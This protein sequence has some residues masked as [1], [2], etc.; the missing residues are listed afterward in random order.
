MHQRDGARSTAF[1]LDVYSQRPLAFLE[2]ASAEPTGH[3][4][5]LVVQAGDETRPEWLASAEIVCDERQP[6]DSVLFRI[7]EEPSV[8]FFISG[9][10]FGAFVLSTDGAHLRCMPAGRPDDAWQRLLIAQVLPFA[11]LLHD[12]EVFHASAVVSDGRAVAFIG[13]SRAGKTSVA[14]E[15]CL[16]GATFLADD[17]LAL[18]RSEET[19]LG[20]AGTPVAGLDHA[21]AQRLDQIEGAQ[22]HEVLASNARERLVRMRGASTPAELGAIFILDR[23]QDGPRIP[24]FETVVEPQLLLAATFNS[25]ITSPARLRRLLDVCALAARGRVER[26]LAGPAVNAAQLA[27][28]VAERLDATG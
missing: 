20:H 28:A 4:L 10:Q 24:S 27:S 2:G 19:L 12:L 8:G 16:Q 26:I 7:E 13:P 18:E 21:E 14:F 17:V 3:A 5:E 22:D 6:D 1:G 23:H 25:V 9:P 15:L 11:A